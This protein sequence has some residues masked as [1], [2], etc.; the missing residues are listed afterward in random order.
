M[1]I[2]LKIPK[3][4]HWKM[5]LLLEMTI[6]LKIQGKCDFTGSCVFMRE[7]KII[8]VEQCE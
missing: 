8:S 1:A 3:P 6:K 2:S 4:L 7:I 5:Q